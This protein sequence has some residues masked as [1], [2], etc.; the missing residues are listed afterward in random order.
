M[1]YRVEKV[2][3]GFSI[4]FRQWQATHSHCHFLHGYAISFKLHFQTEDLDT[5]NWVWD[6]G[7]LK[8]PDYKIDGM[9]AKDWFS[10]MFDHTTIIAEDDPHFDK[11][12]SLEAEGILQLR[13]VPQQSC[14]KMAEF[15]LQ[16]VGTLVT[17]FSNGRVQL[18]KVDVFE[19]DKNAASCEIN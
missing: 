9:T 12:K 10:Y 3:D 16:K 8:N 15:V 13:V 11:F 5:Y 6:F 18:N 19:H 7:W 17:E 1:I 4:C 14:E 2:L